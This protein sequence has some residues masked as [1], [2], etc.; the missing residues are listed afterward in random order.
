[1]WWEQTGQHWNCSLLFLLFCGPPW[2][3]LLMLLFSS[4][5]YRLP[6][7]CHSAIQDLLCLPIRLSQ[8]ENGAKGKQEQESQTMHF[9]FLWYWSLYTRWFDSTLLKFIGRGGLR[10][11]PMV[12]VASIFGHCL[13]WFFPSLPLFL[14]HLRLLLFIHFEDNQKADFLWALI[15]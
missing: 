3:L 11:P 13:H 7:S 14:L 8:Q 15:F 1:M 4:E 2:C 6:S 5:L 10:A 12:A 9:L